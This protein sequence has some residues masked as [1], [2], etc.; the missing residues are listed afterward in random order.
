MSYPGPLRATKNYALPVKDSE[1]ESTK[2]QESI[3]IILT[4]MDFGWIARDKQ[5]V[6]ELW[7]SGVSIVDIANQVR[8]G[9]FGQEEVMF[10]IIHMI[11]A[12]DIKKRK[13]GMLGNE[14][15]RQG[16]T[17]PRAQ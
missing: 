8:P 10:L 12:K 16:K 9:R 14:G 7:K 4:D 15:K 5:Q 3:E 2:K 17:S 6:I 1:Y 13:G 11:Y